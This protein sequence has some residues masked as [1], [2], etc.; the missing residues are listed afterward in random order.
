M[1]M[2]DNHEPENILLHFHSTYKFLA[3][4]SET[5]FTLLHAVPLHSVE[6]GDV[7][8]GAA[9]Q[10][11]AALQTAPSRGRE[12]ANGLVPSVSL[13]RQPIGVATMLGTIDVTGSILLL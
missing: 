3:V 5:T 12:D 10:D 2:S 13:L 11:G 8:N 6:C 4:F 7:G 9:G 1:F